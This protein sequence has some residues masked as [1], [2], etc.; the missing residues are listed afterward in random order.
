MSF[1]RGLGGADTAPINRV[2]ETSPSLGAD[3]AL[4]LSLLIKTELM[5]SYSIRTLKENI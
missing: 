3:H 1:L 5:Y 2:F 4:Y